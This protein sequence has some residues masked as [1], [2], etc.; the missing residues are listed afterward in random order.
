[1]EVVARLSG[2]GTPANLRTL[3]RRRVGVPPSAYRGTF[4]HGVAT[5]G[6]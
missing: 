3:F 4:R 5:G 1:M 6:E 2:L